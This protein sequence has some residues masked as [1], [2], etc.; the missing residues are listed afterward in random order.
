MTP[1]RTEYLGRELEGFGLGR[2]PGCLASGNRLVL[3]DLK[4]FSM[5]ARN[6]GRFPG[7]V[8]ALRV[9]A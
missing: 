5:L 2:E 4:G 8:V 6:R 1:A 7:E 9:V 3:A